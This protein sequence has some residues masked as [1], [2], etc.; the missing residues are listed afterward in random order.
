MNLQTHIRSEL[1]Q[2][3]AKTY[4]AKNFSHAIL[5]AIH[6]LSDVIREKANVDGD[7][8]ALAGQAFGGDTPRLRLSKLQTQSEK[9][10]QK[11][12]EQ[13]LRGI[14]Q[15]IR[16]P[17]SHEQ[18]VDTQETADAIVHF[19]N[20]L[21]NI[22]EQSQEPYSI[23]N[24]LERI[25]DPDFVESDRYAT[26]LISEIPAG[27]RLDTLIEIYR[28]KKQGNYKKLR[29]ILN[30]II[31]DLTNDQ[32]EIF[33]SIVSE[34]LK[35]T[36]DDDVVRAVFQI[37]PPKLWLQVS[38]ISKLR[39]ED[40]ILKSIWA[41]NWNSSEHKCVSGELGSWAKYFIK[42]FTNKSQV[43][44]GL[45][46]RLDFGNFYFDYVIKFFLDILPEIIDSEENKNR[47]VKVISDRVRKENYFVT[48]QLEIF[49]ETAPMDWIDAFHD[50][51]SDV[52]DEKEPSF[53][54]RDGRPFLNRKL[55]EQ[56]D[57]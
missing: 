24:F 46:P 13:I 57:W 32:I 56:A 33:M 18:V 55:Y 3:I 34:E 20:H 31:A 48:N 47:I 19:I 37:L 16:N 51:L 39:I 1:W 12:F 49:L 44:R 40:K 5:D 8:S 23:G 11:G 2:A 50:S 43:V 25:L 4:E 21:L 53:Y 54:L 7:G 52:T 15:G 17:R 10:F 30:F 35:T 6:F 29:L 28:Q 22:I 42:Y 14:Y 36:H 27:K 26:L 45:I 41:G 38:E 9:D